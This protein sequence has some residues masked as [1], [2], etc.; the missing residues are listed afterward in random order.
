VRLPFSGARLNFPK[1][2]GGQKI[3]SYRPNEGEA[4][5]SLVSLPRLEKL[6]VGVSEL[7]VKGLLCVNLRVR[8][9]LGGRAREFAL[10]N[11]RDEGLY[12][13]Q[14]KD[15]GPYSAANHQGF[16]LWSG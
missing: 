7:F 11:L 1:K 12:L 9:E 15:N 6:T 4:I 5:L 14:D 16:T 13:A 2:N 3:S 8:V 10:F